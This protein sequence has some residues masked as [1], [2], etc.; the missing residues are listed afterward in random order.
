MAEKTIEL[1]RAELTSGLGAGVLGAGLGTLLAAYLRPYA[2]AVVALGAVMHGYGMWRKHRLDNASQGDAP[3]WDGVLYW[4]C[5][6]GLAAV[7]LLAVL[8]RG[9]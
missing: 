3:W 1:K 7:A 2:V 8:R 4:V 5:W 9:T 6:I